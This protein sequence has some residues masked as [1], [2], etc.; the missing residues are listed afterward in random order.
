MESM[1]EDLLRLS[2]QQRLSDHEASAMEKQRDTSVHSSLGTD[3]DTE[4][5][6][7]D[8]ELSIACVIYT[9]AAGS[10]YW[11]LSW[12]NYIY[13][14]KLPIFF[15]ILQ[16]GSWPLQ[17]L[18]YLQ[19]RKIYE[20]SNGKRVITPTMLQSYAVLGSLNAVI[21]LTRTVGLTSLPPTV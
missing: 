18:V 4:G 6:I 12:L 16:N 21:T 7:F 14:I 2:L 1:T 15:A 9:F 19:E 8:R 20:R 11:L 10:E 13:D 5:N 17:G 3:Q